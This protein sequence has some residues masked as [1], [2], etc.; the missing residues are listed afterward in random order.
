MMRPE[1]IPE[2]GENSSHNTNTRQNNR[3]YRTKRVFDSFFKTVTAGV[4]YL[5]LVRITHLS[6]PCPVRALT[7]FQCPGCGIT[8][9]FAALSRLDF[10]TAYQANPFIFMMM[11]F[12]AFYY[13]Y[14]SWKYV[15]C[16]DTGFS[17]WEIGI[18]VLVFA[19]AVCFAV[20]RNI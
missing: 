2:M 3:S 10:E 12:A 4:F 14:R 5:F 6:I 7:G 1:D 11:P 16:G 13:L 9:Y 15:F 17:V 20:K 18:L 19:A 8:R